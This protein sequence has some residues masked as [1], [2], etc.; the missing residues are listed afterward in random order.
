MWSER[1]YFSFKISYALTIQDKLIV[2]QRLSHSDHD[3]TDSQDGGAMV[4]QSVPNRT[5]HR[6]LRGHA[7]AVRCY[8]RNMLSAITTDRF[9]AFYTFYSV[10]IAFK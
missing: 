1:L 8:I 6:Y 5:H 9:T 7:A 10:L 4:A 3:M 2:K